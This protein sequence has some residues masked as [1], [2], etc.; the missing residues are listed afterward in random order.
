[1]KIL[2]WAPFINKVGTTS[3][4]IN[5]IEALMTYPRDKIYSVDLINAFGEWDNYTFEDKKINVI[6]LLTN[7]FI[8]KADKKGFLK[9]RFYTILIFIFAAWPLFKLIKKNKYDYII[10][11]LI[12][13]LP[14]T[15]FSLINS[16]SK[17]ILSIS[18]FPKLTNFRKLFW[19]FSKNNIY[20]II[21]PSYETKELLSKARIFNSN[22]LVVIKDPHVSTKKILNFSKEKINDLPFKDN[23]FLISI[24]RLTKQ[25]NFIFLI[26][27][28]KNIQKYKNNLHLMII[29]DGEEK[30]KIEKKIKELNLIDNVHLIGYQKK[31]L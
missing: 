9:S 28:F 25:K 7:K 6:N 22:Q 21:C 1:M 16:S 8:L 15:L 29:G 11:Y 19:K 5:S 30:I 2:I 27:A 18:G 12:T 17:L 10:S 13:S 14:I 24:G 26:E 20:K 3:N 23:K 4:V 31:Y